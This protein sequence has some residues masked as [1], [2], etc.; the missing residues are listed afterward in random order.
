[1]NSFKLTLH[2]ESL[3]ITQKALWA[4]RDELAKRAAHK[5]VVY[6]VPS[7]DGGHCDIYGVFI[8]D[9]TDEEIAIIGDGFRGDNGG[10]GGAGHRAAQALMAIYGL[11]PLE[12]MPDDA[13]D[14]TENMSLYAPIARK[15]Q[16][17]AEAENPRVPVWLAPH[18]VDWVFASRR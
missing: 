15:L 7:V 6:R 18:Y 10:E 8:I 12:M 5:L 17:Y 1:M 11:N 9:F 13:I 16:D 14:Y 3:G 2:E 4:L